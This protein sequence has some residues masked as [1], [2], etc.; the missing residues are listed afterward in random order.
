MPPTG[1]TV[2]V[3]SKPQ[4]VVEGLAQRIEPLGHRVV[5]AADGAGLL[6]L[7]AD[8][9]PGVVL[10][11]VELP[12]LDMAALRAALDADPATAATPVVVVVRRGRSR[13][14]RPMAEALA[15]GA[16]DLLVLPASAVEVGA[17]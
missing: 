9:H 16:H 4:A 12:G 1:A 13:D 8:E 15:S 6:R 17:R 14:E 3:A 2:A 10:A 7:V 11:D 5:A